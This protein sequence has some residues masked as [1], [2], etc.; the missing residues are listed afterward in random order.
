MNRR[1]TSKSKAAKEPVPCQYDCGRVAQGSL[2]I[3]YYTFE[4][5]EASRQGFSVTIPCCR[6]CLKGAVRV[7]FTIPE[8]AAKQGV[9]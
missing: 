4:P 1:T 9:A 3:Y 7:S 5:D 8:V 2:S 6:E